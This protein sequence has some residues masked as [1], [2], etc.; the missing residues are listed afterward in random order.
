MQ[1][2]NEKLKELLVSE[3]LT[4]PQVFDEVVAE[5]VRMGQEPA[6]LL[7]SR[8]I[9]TKEYFAEVLATYFGVKRASLSPQNV[10]E[11]VLKLIPEE[12]ARDKRVIVFNREADGSYAV[13]ME[14]PSDLETIEFLQRSLNGD[15]HTYLASPSDLNYGLSLYSKGGAED[16]RKLIEENVA[17]TMRSRV[18]GIEEAAQDLPIV[19]IVDNL[20]A[21]A[22]ASR[23]SDIH[24]EIMEDGLLVRYRID[25]VLHEIMRL[26]REV[27]SPITA[28]IKLLA[29][30]K[31]D[32]HSRPQ[33]GRFRQRLGKDFID[34]RVSI[35]PTFYGEKTE[36]RLL[37]GAQRPLSFEEIGMLEDTAKII[38]ENI[39]KTFGMVLVSGPTG[40]GKTTTLYSILNQLN[41]PEINIVTV[42][43]PVE[44]NIKYVNQTQ[45]NPAAGITFASALRSLL[46]Q[47]P[48]VILV[49]EIRD[50]ETAEI[51]VNSALTGH[52]VLS[53]VHTNDAPTVIPRL[54]DMK[55][56]SFL[57]AAVLNLAMA[58]RLVGRICQDCI[59]SY[60]PTAPI[61]E[62]I[63]SQMKDLGIPNYKPAKSFYRGKG[64]NKCGH[65]GLRGRIG[66]FETMSIDEEIRKYIV[67]PNF[68]LDGMRT[69]AR[70]KGM[71][72]MFE[73]GLRKVERG[74]TTIEEVLRVIRE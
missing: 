32:E 37:A 40:S 41:T 69:L 14:D 65:S 45:I 72:T 71:I 27:H 7:I 16:F 36:M 59:E 21:Y 64:C 24:L 17:A 10:D 25:G 50:E 3:G 51:S 4:T 38:Q 53:T 54:F 19:A 34:L 44:Y 52:L 55:V 66:I 73:D 61:L 20:I 39:K 48:N 22:A 12:V 43:D 13:A 33:D 1:I 28:R 26:P 63:K 58:Q 35:I 47:D 2:P 6:D 57:V 8:G 70:K 15:V 11:S 49:G 30:L 9:L 42:E 68:S 62:L 29:G 23:A 67:D 56:P 18:T 60:E 46:R 74:M 31:L 5:A